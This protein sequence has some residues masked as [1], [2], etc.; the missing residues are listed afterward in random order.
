MTVREVEE[1]TTITR[2]R[3][4]YTCDI[5]GYENYIGLPKCFICCKDVCD[6]CRVYTPDYK[7][8]L[9]HG[10]ECYCKECWNAGKERMEILDA[11]EKIFRE[12]VDREFAVWR[13]D[14]SGKEVNNDV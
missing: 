3:I 14:I 8:K 4:M 7:H 5:C 6:H 13:R 12:L 2:K 9:W 1:K 11:A 10:D